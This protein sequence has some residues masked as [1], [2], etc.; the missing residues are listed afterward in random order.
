MDNPSGSFIWYELMTTDPQAAAEFYGPVVGWTIAG[1]ADPQAGGGVDYRMIVRG[2]G[3]HA[4]GVLGLSKEMSEG[5]A[6]PCWLGYI[7]VPDIDAAIAAITADGGSLQMPATDLPVGRI[8]MVTDPQGAPFYLMTPKPPPGRDDATSDVF[9][10]DRPQHVRW[11]ELS[12]TDDLA[13]VDFYTRHF[14]W[15]QQGDMDMGALGKYRFIQHHDVGIGA[16]MPRM[17]EMPVTLWSYYIGVDDIDR[18][19]A[20]VTAGGGTLLNGPMEIPGGEFAANGMDPQG[21]AFGLVGPR[22]T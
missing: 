17:P 18:A 14:G 9:S 4:G 13:A 1:H 12:T 16:I 7:Y 3:G 19:V 8:A 5:G 21:A 15:T 22:K 2:D 6:R 20:A 10:V 11:N